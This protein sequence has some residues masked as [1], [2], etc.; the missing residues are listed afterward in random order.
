[1]GLARFAAIIVVTLVVAGCPQSSTFVELRSDKK[2][3]K[4]G[5]SAQLV[6]M[7]ETKGRSCSGKTGLSKL[8]APDSIVTWSVDPERGSQISESG[9]FTSQRPGTYKV[10]ASVK[11]KDFPENSSSQSIKVL[12]AG[13]EEEVEAEEEAD[14][15]LEEEPEPE[16]SETNTP[17]ALIMDNHNP[18]GVFNGG[19]PPVFKTK[20]AVRVTMIETYHWNDE[21]GAQRS[22]R[23]SLRSAD[24]ESYGPFTARGVEGQGGVPN[25]YWRASMDLELPPGSYTIIDSKPATWSQNEGTGGQGMVRIYGGP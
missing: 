23:I 19:S 2:T 9:V 13:G 25:A 7:V 15:E 22:G 10:S 4:V 12:G 16:A 5:E 11:P 21:E 1:M 17:G 24:G 18:Q 14:E 6:A 3:L 20:K 8:P